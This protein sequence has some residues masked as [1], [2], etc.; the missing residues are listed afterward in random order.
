MSSAVEIR[1]LIKEDEPVIE[2]LLV[3][4]VY[5]WSKWI[6]ISLKHGILSAYPLQVSIAMICIFLFTHLIFG[7]VYCTEEAVVIVLNSFMRD[8]FVRSQTVNI[9]RIASH[10]CARSLAR[11]Q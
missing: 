7:F 5:H 3:N 10:P 9:K 11:S 1:R 6:S 4:D 8:L 2:D